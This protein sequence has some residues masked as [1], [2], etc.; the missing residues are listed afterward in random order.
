MPLFPLSPCILS[1]T[2]SQDPT[3]PTIARVSDISKVFVV[4]GFKV[5]EPTMYYTNPT[6]MVVRRRVIGEIRQTRRR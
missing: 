5:A 2:F 1:H 4:V 6:T 3:N